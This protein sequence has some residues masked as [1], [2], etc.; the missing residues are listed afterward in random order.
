MTPKPI[1]DQNKPSNRAAGRKR[2]SII[3]IR[4][5]HLL[6]NDHV[7][8]IVEETFSDKVRNF[9]VVSLT[10]DLNLA[11]LSL[12]NGFDIK[13]NLFSQHLK[14][15][16][17][18]LLRVER[19]GNEQRFLLSIAG[20]SYSRRKKP[21][22]RDPSHWELDHD[23]MFF[24]FGNSFQ[25]DA[26]G[27]FTPDA[28]QEKIDAFFQLNAELLQWLPND[29]AHRILGYL[30]PASDDDFIC[31]LLPSILRRNFLHI[32]G[33]NSQMRTTKFITAV[34]RHSGMLP[35]N[36]RG[37]VPEMIAK[38]RSRRKKRDSKK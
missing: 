33:K 29:E 26:A 21:V 9:N 7:N 18:Q 5:A 32:I 36:S 16:R 1:N 34:L 38:R 19:I 25:P 15:L 17:N 11:L 28:V 10:S 12:Y 14:R 35:E 24:P 22:H 23:K 3:N 27:H 2:R 30:K 31:K 6:S 4:R 37:S 13:K 8:K 20:R